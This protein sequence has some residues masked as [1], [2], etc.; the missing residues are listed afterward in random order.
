MIFDFLINRDIGSNN[1]NAFIIRSLIPEELRKE[2]R[3][4][5]FTKCEKTEVNLRK[6]KILG[7]VYHIDL[8]YQPP[9]P[10]DMRREIFLTTRNPRSNVLTY[11]EMKTRGR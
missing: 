6:Y 9:Q 2:L 11:K 1:G 7:G 4:L 10:K 8:L 3:K 5:L